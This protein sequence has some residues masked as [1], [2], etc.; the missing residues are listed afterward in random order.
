MLLRRTRGLEVKAFYSFT[1][2]PVGKSHTFPDGH[3]LAAGPARKRFSLAAG[4]TR[5]RFWL[6]VGP[7]RKRFSFCSITDRQYAVFRVR[8]L[9]KGAALLSK[10]TMPST[11]NTQPS[12]I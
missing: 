1:L 5:K 7:A 12:M 2:Q 3:W 10:F 6:A 11:L 4:P 8:C 9:D